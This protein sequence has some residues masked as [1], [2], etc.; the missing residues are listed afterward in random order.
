MQNHL[1]IFLTIV[2]SLLGCSSIFAQVDTITVLSALP[3]DL[4][5]SSGLASSD[6]PGHYWS[7]NNKW[8]N[9]D[10]FVLGDVHLFEAS[11]GNINR[12]VKINPN[13]IIAFS[14]MEDMAEDESGYTYIGDIGSANNIGSKT[15]FRIHKILDLNSYAHNDIVTSELIDFTYPNN[16]SHNAEAMFW[17]DDYIYIF[18]KGF[19]ND[20][21][22]ISYRVPDAP[23][24]YTAEY[25][26]TVEASFSPSLS[27]AD[28][29]P[30]NHTIAFLAYQK[31]VV[32][33]C[34]TA[35]YVFTGSEMYGIEY[36]Y[37]Q[38]TNTHF[39]SEALMFMDE[40]NLIG[41]NE[42][43]DIPAVS[44]GVWNLSIANLVANNFSCLSESCGLIEN[45]NFND[46]LN[47]W[48]SSINANTVNANIVI[49]QNKAKIT[50]D[51][52]G[53]AKWKVRLKQEYFS[54][55]VATTY[56][57]S[58]KAS[59]NF[60]REINV[61]V[62]QKINNVYE[63]YTYQ[64]VAITPTETYYEYEFTTTEPSNSLTRITFDCGDEQFS[65]VY[66]DDVC[67]EEIT[68]PNYVFTTD[69]ISSATYKAASILESRG[70]LKDN[71]TVKYEAGN[72]INLKDDF[73]V[74][75]KA[76]FEAV[77]EDCP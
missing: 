22:T 76:D 36:T 34:F 12:T 18:A 32:V 47:Y 59:A 64:V 63:G 49:D 77:I 27:S 8:V 21:L 62:G 33:K 24:T 73:S 5:E 26:E 7:H 66:I 52:G 70:Q 65:E 16:E 48:T 1:P 17:Y 57:L 51:D 50:M 20:T 41:T 74:P 46:G 13:D 53:D 30:Q 43:K 58:F 37:P 61:L 60:N 40:F 67:L 14:D 71:S 68:C 10:P 39:R 75:K 6:I 55:L 42:F 11:T 69:S 19:Q 28:I 25:L 54:T 31:L 4:K 56:K 29:N 9:G 35:P 45:Y 38:D 72:C 23:G 44:Q 2:I 3:L 15:Q